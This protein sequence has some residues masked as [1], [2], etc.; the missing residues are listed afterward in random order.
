MD[1]IRVLKSILRIFEMVFGLKIN[2]AKSQFG[3]MGKSE[4]WYREAAL[5]L[6]CGQLDIPF[7]YLGIPPIISKFE[8]KL[9]KWK[10]KSLSMG[11]R[12]TLINY[13]LTMLPIYLLSFF[14]VP[15][16][17]VHKLVS[18]QRNFL[19]GG[20]SEVTKIAWVNWDTIFLPKNKGGLGIKDLS[21]FNEVLL[22][23]WVWD[24]ANNQ[25]QF[26]AR[27]LMS[28]YGGWN[29]LCYG[30]NRDDSSPWW[31]DLRY[32]FQQHHGNCIFNNL[33][34]KWREDDLSLQDKYPTLYQVS[35]QQNHTIN[36]M[37]LLI[38]SRWEWKVQ[39][40]RHFFDHEIDT[41]AAFMADIEGGADPAG[42]YST[43]LAY[44]LL[45]AEG[46]SISEDSNYK[47]I[48]RLKI[49][50]EQ[51]RLP[52]RDNLRRRHVELPSY[53][54]PLCDQDEETAGHIMY[55]CRKTR[56]LWWE[57]LRWAN[58]V[59]PFPIE[60]KCH[61]LQFSQWSGKSNVDNR[62]KAFRIALSM[63][64]WKHRNALVFN[65]Q[66]FSTIKVMDEALFHTWSWINCMEKD[67]HT[68]FNQWST[69]L[70]EEM[71]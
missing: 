59:G 5:F 54:C 60:P 8:L 24:L 11:G 65:N 67:F 15:K 16:K 29:A 6:N 21:K 23:K 2:Y 55:S 13:V 14:R 25:D 46:N 32:V 44:N 31:K 57:S 27:I 20:G 40:R 47:I 48:W 43:K 17:V 3:C 28:K 66:N 22:G 62:W 4:V 18:I 69:C 70:K 41:M 42:Y 49:P 35:T 68:H 51:N 52:T 45:K 38:G 1:N 26:W 9:S 61:F 63:T 10:Q 56:H 36:S 71:S 33:K 30:R 37:G 50:Q 7:S 19:W 53:N 64:I 12:I 34:W 58:R 39:W